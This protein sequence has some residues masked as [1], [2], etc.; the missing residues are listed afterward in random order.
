MGFTK[1]TK[2]NSSMKN[3]YVIN[4]GRRKKIKYA[5]GLCYVNICINHGILNIDKK[6]RDVAMIFKEFKRWK[7]GTKNV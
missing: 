2:T 3:L 7:F 6:I 1:S 4:G 5:I